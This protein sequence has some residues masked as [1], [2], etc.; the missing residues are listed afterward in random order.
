M[1]AFDTGA[2]QNSASSKYTR[3]FP[4]PPPRPQVGPPLGCTAR[5]DVRLGGFLPVSQAV[6]QGV[7]FM[8]VQV[9]R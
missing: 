6:L 2:C 5:G 4:P 7:P 9:L 8:G 3:S 1:G